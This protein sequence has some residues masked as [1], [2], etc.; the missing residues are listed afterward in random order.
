M[1]PIDLVAAQK[2]E[3]FVARAHP[4]D[5]LKWSL[6]SGDYV[7]LRCME[8]SA[9]AYVVLNPPDMT[10]DEDNDGGCPLQGELWVAPRLRS[11]LGGNKVE[12]DMAEI[13]EASLVKLGG[14]PPE[15]MHE[16]HIFFG[17]ASGQ[18]HLTLQGLAEDED[19]DFDDDVLEYWQ[20]YVEKG[21]C[22][23]RPVWR[24]MTF[25]V[26]MPDAAETSLRGHSIT[27]A[28]LGRGGFDVRQDED[29]CPD[30]SCVRVEAVFGP[31]G[32]PVDA[33]IVGPATRLEGDACRAAA[34]A[35]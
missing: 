8:T 16:M 34:P 26:C 5:A 28:S 23:M 35:A 19:L 6:Y 9:E 2:L 4:E 24:G 7:H 29:S 18:S 12:L 27:F 33:A 1:D 32:R 13:E 10:T 17:T 14:V 15:A 21:R 25:K 22:A 3:D 30:A 11:L 20:A 31:G